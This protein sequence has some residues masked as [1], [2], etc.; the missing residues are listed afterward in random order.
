MTRRSTRV[1]WGLLGACLLTGA[2][3]S[4]VIW[5]G[6]VDPSSR[7]VVRELA[8]VA[9]IL[10]LLFWMLVFAVYWA[11]RGDGRNK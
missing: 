1:L 5:L 11:S 3:A 7:A 10:A 2:A 9:D 8:A 6:P 4:L